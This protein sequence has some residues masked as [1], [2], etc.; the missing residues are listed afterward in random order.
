MKNQNFTSLQTLRVMACN[1]FELFPA[2]GLSA[3]NLTSI[4]LF[5]LK[6]KSLPEKMHTLLPSLRQLFLWNCPEIECF[7]EGG[8]PSSLEDRTIDLCQTLWRSCR[9]EWGLQRLPS[10]THFE[11]SGTDEEETL[12]P[13][14][15]LLPSTLRSLRLASHKD[16]KML[17]FEL[18]QRITCLES[19]EIEHCPLL[20]SLPEEGLPE[21]LSRLIIDSCP[22][23]KQRLEF[24]KGEDWH[25]VVHI[26]HIEV[27]G[28]SAPY[29]LQNLLVALLTVSTVSNKGILLGNFIHL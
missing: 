15:F 1:N 7:P 11:L 27:D 12:L 3:P 24:E 29:L 25:K 20:H 6:L 4:F 18:L 19:L 22:L 16:L 21:S 9:R 14:D 26:H 8:L 23:L 17:N 5:D 13:D 10:L 28:Y 2:G